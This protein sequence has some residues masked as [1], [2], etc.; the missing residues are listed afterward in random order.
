MSDGHRQFRMT[1]VESP[2]RDYSFRSEFFTQICIGIV[3]AAVVAA[4]GAWFIQM[5][6]EG[7]ETRED[8]W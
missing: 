8:P 1:P 4:L 2:G 5:M 7:W 3:I 6:F